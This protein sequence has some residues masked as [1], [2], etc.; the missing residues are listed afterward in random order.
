MKILI[1]GAAG[2]I[3]SSLAM[4]LCENKRNK[5]YG[6]DNLDRYSGTK[7]KLLRLNILKKNK[8]FT[9]IKLDLKEKKILNN[10]IKKNRFKII[11]HFAAMVGV[12]YSLKHPEAYIKSNILGFSNLLESLRFNLPKKI[13]Y[14]SSSSVYGETKKFPIHELQEL[15]PK[16]IY[17][18][19]KKNNEDIAKIYSNVYKTQF[20][21]LRFFTVFGEMGRPDMFIFKL[22]RSYFRKRVFY[23]NNKGN[24][25]RDFTYIQD[26]KKIL[27]FFLKTNFFFKN[28]VFNVC[29]N[30]PINLNIIIKF[31]EKKICKLIIKNISIN[32]ADVYKTHGSNLKIRAIS[33]IKRFTSYKVAIENT[34]N[35]YRAFK[36]YNLD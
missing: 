36:I 21:G 10:L 20:I 2:F 32:K 9:F 19:T 14:A 30:K 22:L 17:A 23:L 26:L 25:Y 15:N 35:W 3:G 33:G 11:Y 18:L 13:I 29:S 16:N 7:L 27:L 1:T 28:E 31:L 12:R 5:V 6:I 8:N 34:L 24:H 4:D